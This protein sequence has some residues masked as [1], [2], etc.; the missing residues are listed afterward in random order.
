MALMT[1]MDVIWRY[2]QKLS[3]K[4]VKSVSLKNQKK[5]R[6]GSW[7]AHCSRELRTFPILR[8]INLPLCT[9]R[10]AARR[11]GTGGTG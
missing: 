2:I 7:G 5:E 1:R 3:V 6:P 4:S 8:N 10:K 11:F 9:F